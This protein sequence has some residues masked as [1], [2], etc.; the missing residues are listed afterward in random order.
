MKNK[1]INKLNINIFKEAIQNSLESAF[2]S[3]SS[4]VGDNL[5]NLERL[6][7]AQN[8][9]SEEIMDKLAANLDELFSNQKNILINEMNKKIDQ[10]LVWQKNLYR[11]NF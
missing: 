9:H 7:L 1:N 8:N 6:Q 3:L 11:Q 4:D 5:F 10:S 2:E